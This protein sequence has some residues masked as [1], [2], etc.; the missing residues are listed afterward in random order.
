M[1]KKSTL[2]PPSVVQ[3]EKKL[4]NQSLR[5]SKKTHQ[6]GFQHLVSTHLVSPPLQ[7][8]PHGAAEGETSI[9]SG[10]RSSKKKEYRFCLGDVNYW[11]QMMQ[12]PVLQPTQG[13]FPQGTCCP[14]LGGLVR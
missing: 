13:P 4:R 3:L 10:N 1:F 9:L 11:G 8:P 7:F 14:D 5:K 2:H 6:H 12:T